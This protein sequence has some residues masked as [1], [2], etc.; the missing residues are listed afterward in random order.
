MFCNRSD[1]ITVIIIYGIL[2]RCESVCK[3]FEWTEKKMKKK[4]ETNRP[5]RCPVICSFLSVVAAP[6]E[7]I[8]WSAKQRAGNTKRALAKQR[9]PRPA[10][11]YCTRMMGTRIA[12]TSAG[13]KEV[14]FFLLPGQHYT[15]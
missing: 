12:H 10:Q 3:K 5:T 15:P 8:S 13:Y 6:T 7:S 2:G 11:Q 14:V 4:N 9:A 1:L